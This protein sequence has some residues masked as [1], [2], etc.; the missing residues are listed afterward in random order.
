MI[1]A[2]TAFDPGGPVNKAAGSVALGLNGMSETFDLT[3]R[4]LSIVI[5]PSASALLRSS[6]VALDYRMSLAGGENR[7]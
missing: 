1:A 7:R 2:G 6:T 4:E 3:A 5:P